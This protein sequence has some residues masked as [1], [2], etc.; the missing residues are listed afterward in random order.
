[1]SYKSLWSRCDYDTAVPTRRITLREQLNS[2]VIHQH[3]SYIACCSLFL[4]AA[5]VH[6]KLIVHRHS[7]RISVGINSVSNAFD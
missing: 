7:D 5:I 4:D 2:A 1:M 6:L 3:L